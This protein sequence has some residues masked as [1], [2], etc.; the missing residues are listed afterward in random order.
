MMRELFDSCIR[1]RKERAK[2]CGDDPIPGMRALGMVW[3][4]LISDHTKFRIDPL[5]PNVVS[6]MLAG[7]KLSRACR[8]NEFKD[9]N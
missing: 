7:L 9:D 5:P 6:L 4:G 2:E 1:I 3:A 8:G